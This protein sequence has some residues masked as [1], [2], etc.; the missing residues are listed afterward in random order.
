MYPSR[1]RY[2]APRSLNEAISL[3]HDGG[4]YVARCWPAA[5]AWSR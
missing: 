3:L 4:D 2:E 1:F 5:R